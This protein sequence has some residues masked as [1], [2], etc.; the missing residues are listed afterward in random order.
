M[1]RLRGV[2]MMSGTVSAS[3]AGPTL[4]LSFV[5]GRSGVPI[6]GGI[7]GRPSASADQFR[8][9]RAAIKPFGRPTL[10]LGDFRF[11]EVPNKKPLVGYRPNFRRNATPRGEAP[12]VSFWQQRTFNLWHGNDGFVPGTAGP[13]SAAADQS[14]SLKSATANACSSQK[15]SMDRSDADRQE[16]A[17][18]WAVQRENGRCRKLGFVQ[19]EDRG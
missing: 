5:D 1:H 15:L 8:Y 6:D 4:P 11:S 12:Y 16:G 18:T 19:M 3:Y 2:Y 14:R 9:C 7:S 17:P 13:Y 10:P